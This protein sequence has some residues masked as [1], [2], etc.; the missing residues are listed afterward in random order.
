MCQSC[1]IYLAARETDKTKKE[2]MINYIIEMCKTHYGVDYKYEDINECDGCKSQSG[3]LFFG[4]KDCKIRE[5]AVEKGIDNCAY[6]E[7]YACEELLEM[8][9][10]DPGAKTRLDA[11]RNSI[12]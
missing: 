5:C 2:K 8:F 6:C 10:N 11:I 7:D 1:P 3:R 9:K 4:C 12:S